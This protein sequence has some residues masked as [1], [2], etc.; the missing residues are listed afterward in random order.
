VERAKGDWH[1]FQT[2]KLRRFKNIE[3]LAAKE[4]IWR[5]QTMQ[6]LKHGDLGLP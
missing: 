1:D 4:V 2:F 3:S 5:V 6:T